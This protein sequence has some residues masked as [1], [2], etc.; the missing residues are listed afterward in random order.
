MSKGLKN[1]NIVIFA[2]LALILLYQIMGLISVIWG[3]K[4]FGA[5]PPAKLQEAKGLIPSWVL[6][7]LLVGSSIVLCKVWKNQEKK[8]LIP[9]PPLN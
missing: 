8:S 7:T 3:P 6:M 4:L 2:F 1:L 9:K 5:A